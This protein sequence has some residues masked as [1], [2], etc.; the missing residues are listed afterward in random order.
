MT[1]RVVLLR[2][3][4]RTDER[5]GWGFGAV[6]VDKITLAVVSNT[7]VW[8]NFMSTLG[9]KDAHQ[10]APRYRRSG[11]GANGKPQ[12]HARCGSQ[13]RLVGL[14]LKGFSAG[15]ISP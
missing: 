5:L 2:G 7:M 10:T 15:T 8:R 3:D 14:S 9:Q 1:L 12:T 13:I 6:T 4:P 11:T